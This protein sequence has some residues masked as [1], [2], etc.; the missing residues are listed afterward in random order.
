M[1]NPF[2]AW[3]G[4]GGT[5][6]MVIAALIFL[7]FGAKRLPE[8]ARSLGQ[9]KKEFNK[10]TREI[11]EESDK[12]ANHSPNNQQPPSDVAKKS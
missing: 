5:E 10:A 12:P 2:I 11:T 7:L 3:G 1:I 4:L 6:V 8:L 9:A